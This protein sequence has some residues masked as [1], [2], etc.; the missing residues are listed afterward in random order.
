VKVSAIHSLSRHPVTVDFASHVLK[1]VL[2]IGASVKV[3]Y[4]ERDG[5]RYAR[6]IVS[7]AS[8]GR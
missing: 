3:S 2:P 6:R 1:D 4:E 5:Q 7:L 8:N